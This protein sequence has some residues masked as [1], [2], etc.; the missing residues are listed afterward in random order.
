[1]ATRQ[2][3]VV[4]SNQVK[5]CNDGKLQCKENF[6]SKVYISVRSA[7]KAQEAC[8][9]EMRMQQQPLALRVLEMGQAC[10]KLALVSVI[11]NTQKQTNSSLST[12]L[13]EI[14]NHPLLVACDMNKP[15]IYCSFLASSLFQMNSQWYKFLPRSDSGLGSF[16][17]TQFSLPYWLDGLE[18]S[19]I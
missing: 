11:K 18:G 13:H 16:I 2:I 5:K 19:V 10:Q 17:C 8:I 3:R 9:W 4:I 15:T 6:N 1:M 7:L 14:S 12:Y